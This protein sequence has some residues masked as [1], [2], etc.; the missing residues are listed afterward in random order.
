MLEINEKE[1]QE[2]TATRE[3]W[4]QKRCPPYTPSRPL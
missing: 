1:A 3:Q 2:L 4:R